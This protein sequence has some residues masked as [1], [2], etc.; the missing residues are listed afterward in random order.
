[1]FIFRVQL[2]EKAK[3]DII[4]LA[5]AKLLPTESKLMDV[6]LSMGIDYND[7]QTELTNNTRDINT[8]AYE[9]NKSPLNHRHFEVVHTYWVDS[10]PVSIT[11]M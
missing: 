6:G 7:I 9:V 4:V 3:Q 2:D 1:M 10:S 8:A 5:L 11:I